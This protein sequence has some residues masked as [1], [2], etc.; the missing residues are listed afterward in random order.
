MQYSLAGCIDILP[1]LTKE[2]ISKLFF[3]SLFYFRS[4]KLAFR[5]RNKSYGSSSSSSSRHLQRHVQERAK[6]ER[7][8]HGGRE[9]RNLVTAR[10]YRDWHDPKAPSRVVHEQ[11]A[12]EEVH[13]AV[14]R[15]L[16]RPEWQPW[17]CDRAAGRNSATALQGQAKRRKNGNNQAS[18]IESI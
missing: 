5:V 12:F 4:D 3:L 2:S 8:H 16:L 9:S 6:P 18:L 17:Q 14:H 7:N 11:Q 10:Q 15:A 13:R 1:P